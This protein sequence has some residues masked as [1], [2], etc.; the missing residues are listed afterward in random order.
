MQRWLYRGALVLVSLAASWATLWLLFPSDHTPKGA[1]YRVVAAVNRGS[2]EQ[3]FPY[4]E[5]SAQHA[6]FTLHHYKKD[7]AAQIREHYPEA[8]R[9]TALE[10]VRPLAE[11]DEGPGVF[12]WYAKRFGWLQRLR[13]DLSGVAN[14]EVDGERATVTTVRGTR[15]AFRRRDNGMWG[16]TLFT[17]RLVVDAEKAARDYSVIEA[18]A[19]DFDSVRP[20]ASDR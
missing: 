11:A 4:L 20:G 6:A 2:A 5:T 9:E 3:L 10:R 16:L 15:Y 14:V 18:A 8:E 13:R 12:A 17:A 19:K 7:S 1:Y